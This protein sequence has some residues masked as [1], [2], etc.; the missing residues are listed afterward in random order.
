MRSRTTA[1]AMVLLLGVAACTPVGGGPREPGPDGDPAGASS[2]GWTVVHVVDG[3]TL[4][5]R[6][7]GGAEARVRLIG[8]D[9]PE[10]GECGYEPATDLLARLTLGRPV[11]LVAGARDDADAYG[12][13]LRYVDVDI[14]RRTVD[15][16]L[17]VVRAGLAVTRYDSRDGYGAHA[18]EADYLRADDASAS[19]VCPAGP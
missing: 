15:A 6:D 9:T 1:L 4:D 19:G 18:R 8:I 14:D 7:G 13:L 11:R 3:D 17:A 16:G 2:D 12:R 10:R 5:V